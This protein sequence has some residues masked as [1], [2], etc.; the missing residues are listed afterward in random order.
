MRPSRHQHLR[1]PFPGGGH[2]PGLVRHGGPKK[3]GAAGPPRQ[4]FGRPAPVQE[5]SLRI[6]H[7]RILFAA[8][9]FAGAFGAVGWK[10]V[11][12][13]LMQPADIRVKRTM[14][15]SPVVRR[16]EIVDRN[17]I[18]LA[19]KR[20][21]QSAWADPSMIRDPRFT[22]RRLTAIFP[23]LDRAK[24]LRRLSRRNLKF[25]WIQREITDAQVA[26]IK[27]LGLKGVA[28]R[29]EWRRTWPHGA[30]TGHIIGLAGKDGAGQAGI[31]LR[32]DRRLS[33]GGEALALSIDLRVQMA[34][35]DVL[36]RTV[37]KF[38]AIG[39]SALMMDVRTGEL[40]GMVSL[41]E[42]EPEVRSRDWKRGRFNRNTTGVY[43]MGSTFK[44]FTVALGYDS[45]LFRSGSM[46]DARKPI[47]V[48]GRYIRD[49]HAKHRWLTIEEV[50]QYSSNIGA[51]RIA[52]RA[53]RVRLQQFLGKLG[54][55][56]KPRLELPE[57]G[58]PIVPRH[59][60]KSHTMTIS[61]GHGIAVSPIQLAGAVGAVVNGGLW[62][63]PTL[64][65]VDPATL[66]PARRV[67]SEDTSARMRRLLRLVVEKGTGKKADAP[68]YEV[69]GKTGTAEKAGRHGY[70]RKKLLSS[71]VGVFPIS[72]PRY[73]VLVAIDEP[74]GTKE[75]HGYAT[76]GWVAAPAVREIIL[77]TAP[78]VGMRPN[79]DAIGAT[80]EG[81]DA[82]APPPAM[83]E[84][85]RPAPPTVRGRPDV[86]RRAEAPFGAPRDRRLRGYAAR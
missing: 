68:G 59:W 83:P 15:V 79:R 65:R 57:V 38:R 11:D 35:R 7:G 81:P 67:V 41:P 14:P 5:P 70:R 24:I 86:D 39:G 46:I 72:E 25:V 77:R 55:M 80:P 54:L 2:R 73:L 64:V 50:F 66:P 18:V 6:A 60:R 45:G 22:L 21:V 47:R 74:R 61:F 27:A 31:E 76:G 84:P 32:F 44:I 82:G 49:Y 16:A 53:G 58:A 3:A 40:I 33:A 19:T 8:A 85:R 23:R 36:A 56:S 52:M 28:L 26:Q 75:T 37:R 12:V 78:I 62:R 10:L 1:D 13:T 69:G 17:G 29:Q 34:L 43:E 51:A 20:P 4:A 9:A 71:F 30:V 42:F 48:H 63:R